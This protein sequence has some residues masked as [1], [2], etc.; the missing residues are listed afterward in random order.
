[1]INNPPPFKDLNIGIPII[2][3]IK[4]RGFLNHG[5]TLFRPRGV[6]FMVYLD[7]QRYV[8]SWPL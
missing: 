2:I 6:G 3:P 7:P 5:S 1:M 4:G 8:K